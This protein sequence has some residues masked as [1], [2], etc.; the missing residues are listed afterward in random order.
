MYPT[1]PHT[2]QHVFDEFQENRPERGTAKTYEENKWFTC[3]NILKYTS[4]SCLCCINVF[5]F[6]LL[7]SI[8]SERS[9]TNDFCIIKSITTIGLNTPQ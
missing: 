4:L 3:Q 1:V 7:L 2:P 6:F 9:D 8:N 5:H